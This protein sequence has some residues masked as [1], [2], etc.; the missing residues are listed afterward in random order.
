MIADK[1][2][3]DLV[4]FANSSKCLVGPKKPL[5]S[6]PKYRPID[7]Y[8]SN[9]KHPYWG[10]AH[11]SFGRFGLKTYDDGVYSVRKS[12]DSSEL[13]SPRTIVQEVLLK[14]EK[15]PRTSNDPNE[16]VN[17]FVLTVTHD[18]AFQVPTEAHHSCQNI[19]CCTS[20]NRGVLSKTLQNSACLPITVKSNDSFY[21]NGD[22]KC[23][24]MIRSEIVSNPDEA[25][26]GEILNK[27]TSFIDL[28]IL[29]GSEKSESEKLRSGNIGKLN[30]GSKNLLPTDINGLYT[31]IS[32][33][34]TSVPVSAIWPT[35]FGRN[36]NSLCNE[37]S[38]INPNWDDEKLFQEARRI[39]IAVYQNLIIG[40]TIIEQIFKK[41]IKVPYDDEVNPSTLIEFTT[42]AYRFL[43]YYLNSNMKLIKET[44]E[45]TDIPLSDTFGRINLVEDRFDDALRGSLNQKLN[46]GQY[47]DEIFNK[48]AKNERGIGLDVIA[49]DIQRGETKIFF[50]ILIFIYPS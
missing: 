50:S 36:H 24:T 27:V 8:G 5:K 34:L 26:Y 49:T 30:V 13:P 42:G 39:N 43:H 23:L 1:N 17:F 4:S 11:T 46:Y 19:R 32:N 18:L 10:A 48:F 7:G 37:L 33:R 44:G 38:A 16:M 12:V 22:V 31:P 47:S 35:I 15:Y 29:Y 2:P 45:V 21:K 6:S 28:S 25:Q 14:A 3:A 40:G 20:G 9:V 41:K